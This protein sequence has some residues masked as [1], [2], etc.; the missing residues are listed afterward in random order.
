[1][2]KIVIN[3]I[4]YKIH[5]VYDLYAASKNGKIIHV[6]KHEKMAYDHMLTDIIKQEDLLDLITALLKLL[7][8]LQIKP[9]R[10]MLIQKT[11]SKT[12]LLPIKPTSLML[13]TL[14]RLF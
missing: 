9:A 14:I 13:T 10:R 11:V 6:V 7:L 5:P 3:N 4:E 12:L 8:L 2:S 1:M